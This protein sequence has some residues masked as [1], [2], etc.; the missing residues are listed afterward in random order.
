MNSREH[1]QSGSALTIAIILSIVVA[2]VVGSFLKM[3]TNELRMADRG[4]MQNAVLN[5]AE[6]GADDAAWSLINEDW[7]GWTQVGDVMVK[8][9]TNHDLGNGSSATFTTFVYDYDSNPIVFTEGKTTDSRGNNVVKQIRLEL[10][11]RGYFANGMTAKDGITFVG[12]NAYVDSYNSGDGVYNY[13]T[14]SNDEGSVGSVSVAIDS[15]D[16]GNAT[17]RGYVATGG[18]NPAV[19]SN[20]KIFGDDSD[21]AA[22]EN[23]DWS[24]VSTDFYAD[25]PDVDPPTYSGANTSLTV[26]GT[27]VVGAGGTADFPVVY[28]IESLDI[29][30]RNHTLEVVGHVVIIT[31]GD[32]DIKGEIKITSTGSLTW[33]SDGD[34]TVG[35]NGVANETNV[36]SKMMIYGTNDTPGD[37]LI[38]LHGNGFMTAAV[39]APNSNL[40]L[41][42]GGNS[43]AMFG[44]VVANEIFMNGNYSFHY[45]EALADF[46]GDSNSFKMDD[47]REMYDAADRL[48]FQALYDS[49]VNDG[50]ID[51]TSWS[52]RYSGTPTTTTNPI[53]GE[54][55]LGDGDPGGDTSTSSSSTSSTSTTSSS[56]STTSSSSYGDG[57]TSTS[58][59]TSSSTTSSSSGDD[60]SSSSTSTS[61][62]STSSTSSS[63][64]GDDGKGG[65][66]S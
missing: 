38:K 18:A 12:G 61:S 44:A 64:S 26:S 8:Q 34:I 9:S 56:S 57:D 63:S 30:N 15:V 29:A 52:A 47:W 39:Y 22:G 6:M 41:K 13:S 55:T 35:G 58:S 31:S 46:G 43:G 19:G 36:P 50:S 23:V 16:I 21:L 10:S 49:A 59:S 42:G 1:A 11:T 45:D 65:G 7:D 54:P 53:T 24:R 28:D 32:S 37:T 27:T 51:L 40:D 17:I 66:K 25:F 60:T 3:A 4:F 14:N 48:D 62:T 20:G 2:A 33:Y 5:V